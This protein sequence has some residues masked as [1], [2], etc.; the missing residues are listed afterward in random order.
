MKPTPMTIH[1]TDDERQYAVSV[2]KYLPLCPRPNAGSIAHT[3]L[4]LLHV[5]ADSVGAKLERAESYIEG[6]V[7]GKA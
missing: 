2:S 6:K 4:H 1:L 3:L 7:P 5:S